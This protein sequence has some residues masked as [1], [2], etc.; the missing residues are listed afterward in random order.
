MIVTQTT[1]FG[2]ISIPEDKVIIF[3]DGIP[4]FPESKRFAIL[5]HK[6]TPLKWLQS[7]DEPDLAFLIAEASCVEPTFKIKVDKSVKDYLDVQDEESL[8]VFLILRVENGKVIANFNGPLIFNAEKMLGV[9]VIV[10][11]ISKVEK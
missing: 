2:E 3:K 4:G 1:R 8:I 11:N 7:L 5:D 9:Q 10:D 6:D